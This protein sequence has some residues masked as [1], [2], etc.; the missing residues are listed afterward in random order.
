MSSFIIHSM[1][2]VEFLEAFRQR[3]THRG[4]A[5]WRQD[6]RETTHRQRPVADHAVVELEAA[7]LAGGG[8]DGQCEH[9][10]V[11]NIGVESGEI[12]EVT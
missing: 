7:S 5:P 9:G 4:F 3:E 8:V 10:S 6:V 11:A 1:Y 2:G 12:P